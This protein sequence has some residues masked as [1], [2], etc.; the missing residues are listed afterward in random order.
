M[1]PHRRETDITLP[2]SLLVEEL[3]IKA[4]LHGK[5]AHPYYDGRKMRVGRRLSEYNLSDGARI[6]MRTS[7][8]RLCQLQPYFDL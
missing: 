7:S 4:N 5:N 8:Q 1:N 2:D 6:E 3:I